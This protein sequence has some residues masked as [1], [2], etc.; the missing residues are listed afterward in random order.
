MTRFARVL[1]IGVTAAL[2]KKAWGALPGRV[3]SGRSSKAF[4]RA[5]DA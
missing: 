2:S 3:E 1:V 4:P 5:L